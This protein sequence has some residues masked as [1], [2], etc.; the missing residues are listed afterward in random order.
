MKQITVIKKNT[1]PLCYL[2]N[3]ILCCYS[4][5]NII[6]INNQRIVDRFRIFKNIKENYLSRIRII[7]KALRLGIRSAIAIDNNTIIINIRN[8]L[9]EVDL[10]KKELSN[11]YYIGQGVRPLQFTK[12]DD[13]KGFED[14]IVFGGYV[15]NPNKKPVSIYKRISTDNWEIIYTFPNKAINHIH[16]IVPDPYRQCVWIFTGDTEE[17][18]AIWKCTDNFKNIECF[19][20][21]NQKYRACVGWSTKEGLLYATDSP[22]IDNFIYLLEINDSTCKLTKIKDLSGSCIYGGICNNK[23][24][25]STTVEDNGIYKNN[26]QRFLNRTRGTGIKDE[27]VHLYV[28]TPEQN[29]VDIYQEKKDLLPFIV[30][31]GVFKIPSGLSNNNTLY[32]QPIATTKNDSNLLSIDI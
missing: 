14:S 24:V 11:G 25:F 26:L 22:I 13:I 18:A 19:F 27:F 15:L 3:G 30:Q 32:F 6:M 5:G 7:N 10:T 1:S 23:Y 12:I 21:N 2:P 9:F 17:S 20:S 16:N 8:T 31:Y 4:H 28:G 29:F